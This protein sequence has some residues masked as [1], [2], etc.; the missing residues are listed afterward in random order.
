MEQRKYT[1]SP[2]CWSDQL[3]EKLDAI[4]CR[5]DRYFAREVTAAILEMLIEETDDD[6]IEACGTAAH[7]KAAAGMPERMTLFRKY[8]E[9]TEL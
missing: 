8:T 7:E 2:A 9:W 1:V 5:C 4:R 3:T 6:N